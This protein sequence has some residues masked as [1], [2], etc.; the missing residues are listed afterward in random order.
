MNGK[1]KLSL[2]DFSSNSTRKQMSKLKEIINQINDCEMPI[3]SY[4]GMHKKVILTKKKK[5]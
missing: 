4:R 5:K 1:R 2:T 3:A